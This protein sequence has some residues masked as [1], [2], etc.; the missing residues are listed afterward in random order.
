MSWDTSY[1]PG[2]G[3]GPL[4]AQCCADV[5]RNLEEER[6]ETKEENGTGAHSQERGEGG[7]REGPKMTVYNIK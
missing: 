2:Y 7:G 5:L 4:T 3:P 6:A 1:D